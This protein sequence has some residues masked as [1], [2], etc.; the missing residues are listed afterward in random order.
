METFFIKHKK[1][2]VLYN[3]TGEGGIQTAVEAAVAAGVSLMGA[4]LEGVDLRGVNLKN[5][6]LSFA[7]LLNANLTGA[8]L[9]GAYLVG[10]DM[11]GAD[12]TG[13]DLHSSVISVTTLSGTLLK[14]TIYPDGLRASLAVEGLDQ[15]M[16]AAIETQGGVLD[17]NDWHTC[18]TTHCRA[19]W[20]VVLAGKT[21]LQA[22]SY[23]GTNIAAA[24][25]YEASYPGER[26]PDFFESS[27]TALEDIRQRANRATTQ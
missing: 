22:E 11:G 20:A 1:G 16:L 25:I 17:M 27:D 9:D 18:E 26:I 7:S 5:A 15:K 10:T 2:T 4:N 13:C 19:G 21:G 24:L 23:Y 3:Y 6:D 12:L 14:D 8:N